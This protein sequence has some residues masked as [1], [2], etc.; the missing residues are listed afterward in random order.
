MTKEQQGSRAALYRRCFYRVTVP[1][2]REESV[3]EALEREIPRLQL[4][5][6]LRGGRST[7][8]A[9]ARK[10]GGGKSDEL[11]VRL[12]RHE[13]DELALE[14]MVSEGASERG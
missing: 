1:P 6:F 9:A 10:G 2:N 8:G 13:E 14:D 3:L 12:Y 5:P 7:G 4:W 11:F